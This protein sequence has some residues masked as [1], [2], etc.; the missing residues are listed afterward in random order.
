[1]RVFGELAREELSA[2]RRVR[3]LY[4]PLRTVDRLWSDDVIAAVGDHHDLTIYDPAKPLV[5]QFRDA[6]AVLDTGG[7]VGTHEMMDAA[8]QCRLWQILGTGLDHVDVAYMKSKGFMVA[9]CPGQFSSVALAE[10]AMMYILMLAR[11]CN[12]AVA[13]FHNRVLYKPMGCELVGRTLGLIG[14]GATGQDLAKR[15]KPFGMKIMAIDVRAIEPEVLEAVRPDFVGT[16]ADMDHVIAESDFL[17]LH[18]HLTA[19]TKHIIDRRRLGMMKPTACLINVSRGGLVDEAAMYDALMHGRLGGAGLDAY[20]AEPADPTL[21]VY[22]LPNVI[23]TPHVAGVTDGTSRK[24]ARAA[25]ENVD[26][27]AQNLPLLYRVDGK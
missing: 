26:R 20:A 4:L 14:F 16:P 9:N 10:C 1:L 23:A 3:V 5:E 27:I 8:V 2:M 18:L 11:R 22:R 19:E 17:S 24:R 25:A 7:S 12:E 6:E 13:N 21:P 15:A